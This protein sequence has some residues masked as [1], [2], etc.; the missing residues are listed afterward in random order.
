MQLGLVCELVCELAGVAWP[1]SVIAVDT[2]WW[3]T[4]PALA[5]YVRLTTAQLRNVVLADVPRPGLQWG[6][7]TAT[8]LE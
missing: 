3:A 2:P 1:A 8:R 5:V 4:V 6:G 7:S